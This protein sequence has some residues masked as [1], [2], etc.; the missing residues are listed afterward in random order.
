MQS[1]IAP[2]FRHGP[3]ALAQSSICL[4]SAAVSPLVEHIAT[5]SHW[6]LHNFT[7]SGA[8]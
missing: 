5:F 7:K 8:A 2:L 4:Q 6:S 3:V 1:T